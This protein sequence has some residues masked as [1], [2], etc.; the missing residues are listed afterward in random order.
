MTM[1]P[2]FQLELLIRVA[3][4]VG[5]SAIIGVERELNQEQAGL[6]THSMVGLGAAGFTVTGSIGFAGDFDPTRIAAGIVTGIGFIGAGTILRG[7]GAIRGLSTAASL[8]S[9]G[10]IGMACGAGLF[11]FGGGLTLLALFVL[12]ILERIEQRV[13]R[14]R[15]VPIQPQGDRPPPG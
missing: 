15:W 14:G 1:D 3:V 2:G 9:V 11:V 4:A 8:W 7:E 13:I 6:R 10:A 5:L 12:E